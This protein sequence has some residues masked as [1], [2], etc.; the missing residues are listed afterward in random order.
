MKEVYRYTPTLNV[1]HNKNQNELCCS[2]LKRC[3]DVRN[4]EVFHVIA[5][6]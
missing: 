3:L 5:T 4:R 1:R 6:F 2:D